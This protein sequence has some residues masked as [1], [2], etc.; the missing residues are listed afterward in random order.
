M[1]C[2]LYV[3]YVTPRDRVCTCMCDIVYE[4]VSNCMADP[5]GPLEHF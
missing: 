3:Y 5:G 1:L 2:V 4:C